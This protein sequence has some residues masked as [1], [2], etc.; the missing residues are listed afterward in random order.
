[1]GLRANPLPKNLP[2]PETVDEPE[3]L[4]ADEFLAVYDEETARE[5][6]EDLFDH[7]ELLDSLDDVAITGTLL[8]INPTPEHNP[9]VQ[10]R[11]LSLEEYDSD[12]SNDEEHQQR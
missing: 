6:K 10:A 3:L 12:N 8:Y 7:P 9:R 5:Q 1:L 11:S 2:P 4:S